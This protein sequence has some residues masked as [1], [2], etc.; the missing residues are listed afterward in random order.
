MPTSYQ[1]VAYMCCVL[2]FVFVIIYMRTAASLTNV[3]P[4]VTIDH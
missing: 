1:A 3:D 2:W 4:H